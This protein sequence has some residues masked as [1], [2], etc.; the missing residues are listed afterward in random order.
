[1]ALWLGLHGLAHQRAVLPHFPWPAGIADGLVE[2]LALL[3]A[4]GAG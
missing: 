1:M 4:P 2:R 3:D